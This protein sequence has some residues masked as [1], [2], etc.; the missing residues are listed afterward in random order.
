MVILNT[1]WRNGPA[2][3]AGSQSSFGAATRKT[4]PGLRLLERYATGTIEDGEYH[5]QAVDEREERWLARHSSFIGA[6]SGM[7]FW[8]ESYVDVTDRKEALVR[9]VLFVLLAC[10]AGGGLLIAF[11]NFYLGRLAQRFREVA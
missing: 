7:G 8:V 5:L 11:F 4:T 1:I 6:G 9:S 10:L 3:Q 2:S